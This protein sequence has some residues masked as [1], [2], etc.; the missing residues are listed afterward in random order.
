VRN[1]AGRI[2]AVLC[3]IYNIIEKSGLPEKKTNEFLNSKIRLGFKL[4]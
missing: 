2:G 4:K 1:T 3:L